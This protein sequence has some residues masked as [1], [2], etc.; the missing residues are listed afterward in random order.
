MKWINLLYAAFLVLCCSS[1]S[2]HAFAQKFTFGL[3]TGINA[4]EDFRTMVCP[5]LSNADPVPGCP[6]L[7]GFSLGVSDVS[8]RLLIGP[9]LNIHFSPSFSVEV[10]ALYRPIRTV[11]TRA[12]LFCLPVGQPDCTETPF[13]QS[14]TGTDFSWEFPV[15]ANYQLSGTKMTPFIQV[16]PSFRPKE[17][18]EIWLYC[19]RGRETEAP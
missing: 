12:F 17:N 2:P 4:T 9:K 5:D 19:R 1:L 3:I 8:S 7:V 15:L 16:G 18:G 13:T 10:N 11:N 6:R 14:L